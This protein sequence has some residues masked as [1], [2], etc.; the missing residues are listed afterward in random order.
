MNTST[1]SIIVRG[2]LGFFSQNCVFGSVFADLDY[3][4]TF[5]LMT[6]QTFGDRDPKLAT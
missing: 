2:Y 4:R 5:K 6:G 1:F 3:S